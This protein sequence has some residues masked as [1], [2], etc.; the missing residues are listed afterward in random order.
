M[1]KEKVKKLKQCCKD[2]IEEN[3]RLKT[4]VLTLMNKCKTFLS[5]ISLSMTE[6]NSG[7]INSNL[8]LI[9]SL[10]P[11]NKFLFG[12]ILI[13]YFTNYNVIYLSI[14][15]SYFNYNFKNKFKNNFS[16]NFYF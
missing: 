1:F 11:F 4:Q 5:F 7:L 10:K 9:D 6:I 12:V 8:S 15:L 14:L 16:L 2:K 13:V 3:N